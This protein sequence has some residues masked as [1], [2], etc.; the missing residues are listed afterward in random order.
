M[1]FLDDVFHFLSLLFAVR[2]AVA[3]LYFVLAKAGRLW[4]PISVPPCGS[5]WSL[6]NGFGWRFGKRPFSCLDFV[7]REPRSRGLDAVRGVHIGVVGLELFAVEAALRGVLPRCP[8]AV[9]VDLLLLDLYHCRLD[10]VLDVLRFS[11]QR[12]DL[13]HQ[14]KVGSG[15]AVQF[16]NAHCSSSFSFFWRNRRVSVICGRGPLADLR[17]YIVWLYPVLSA[18]LCPP[19]MI[20]IA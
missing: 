7:K 14:V 12:V 15:L 5:S 17:A 18:A 4:Y 1:P 9:A 6:V 11:G 3:A 10:D 16:K 20:I 19:D 2:A 13:L 8:P